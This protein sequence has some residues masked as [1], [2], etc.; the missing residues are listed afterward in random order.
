LQS[1]AVVLALLLMPSVQTLP[2]GVM[3][4]PPQVRT[5]PEPKIV[6]V[7]LLLALAAQT[8]IVW[9]A[10]CLARA[11]R[12]SRRR[13]A[14]IAASCLVPL[15]SFAPMA[16]L[17]YFAMRTLWRH[18]IRTDIFAPHAGSLPRAAE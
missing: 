4:P 2:R 6:A 17:G 11:L 7:V 16:V 12:C 15:T 8:P 5:W 1:I 14:A 18:G 13:S 9:R 3:P 10:Y